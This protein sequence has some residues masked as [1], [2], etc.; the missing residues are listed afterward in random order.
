VKTWVLVTL[1]PSS[2]YTSSGTM[3]TRPPLPSSTAKKVPLSPVWRVESKLMQ[4]AQPSRVATM[5]CILNQ[6]YC[7]CSLPSTALQSLMVR[8]VLQLRMC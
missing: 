8:S 3:R 6:G 1:R 2:S 7:S 4:R 5:Q